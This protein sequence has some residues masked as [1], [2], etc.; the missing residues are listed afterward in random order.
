MPSQSFSSLLADQAFLA[1][2]S[3]ISAAL[4]L[5]PEI[6][7]KDFMVFAVLKE[8]LQGKLP[9]NLSDLPSRLVFKGGTSLS[10]A[11]GL[12]DRFSE[13]IDLAFLNCSADGVKQLGKAAADGY[14]KGIEGFIGTFP[15]VRSTAKVQSTERKRITTCEY[16]RPTNVGSLDSSAAPYLK[17]HVLLEMDFRTEPFPTLFLPIGSIL[18]DYLKNANPQVYDKNEVLHPF[19]MR[20]MDYKRTLIEK[21]LAVLTCISSFSNSD[22]RERFSVAE[23]ERHFY[24]IHKLYERFRT[25]GHSFGQEMLGI[26]KSSV[27]SDRKIFRTLNYEISDQGLPL[28]SQKLEVV[29]SASFRA[30]Y[31]QVYS[32]SPIYYGTRLQPENIL[33]GVLDYLGQLKVFFGE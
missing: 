33:D 18:G 30:H 32:A 21:T 25:E 10:K 5:P 1:S 3:P 12:I 11:Y 17:P 28:V 31:G 23:R 8:L 14:L 4:S 7:W 20:V 22:G 2:V 9:E 15:F 6:V 19:E 27:E 26:F 13:D 24:D 16:V 29:S